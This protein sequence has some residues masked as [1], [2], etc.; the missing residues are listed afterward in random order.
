[1]FHQFPPRARSFVGDM[2][3]VDV[4]RVLCRFLRLYCQSFASALM[5]A[6]LSAFLQARM[7]V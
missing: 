7:L 3:P 1:M 4:A 5:T 2:I 6:W